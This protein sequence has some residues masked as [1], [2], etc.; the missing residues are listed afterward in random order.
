MKLNIR[1][2]LMSALAAAL[3][4]SV[5]LAGAARAD[6]PR[7]PIV[8]TGKCLMWKVSSDTATVYL[9]GS[10][11][12][13]LEKMYPLP[14]EMEEAFAKSDIVVVEINVN[15]MD[16]AKMLEMVL[17]KGMY[18]PPENLPAK[19]SK[20][21]AAA[22][23]DT[24]KKLGLPETV[25]DQM[26][27]WLAEMSLTVM[28]A[29]K[30]GFSEEKGIDKYFLGKADQAKKP[31][32][33]LED[34][35]FQI[36]LLSGDEEKKQIQSLEIALQEQKER[37]EDLRRIADA[38]V[39]G[40]SDALAELMSSGVKKHPE[41]AGVMKAL[42]DDR[43]GPMAEKAE[44]YLKG[45]KTVF[46]VVGAAHLVGEKGIVKILQDKKYKVERSPATRAKA[47]PAKKAA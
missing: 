40:D 39:A 38:W 37:L 24:C 12:L 42:L 36:N 9:V 19:L 22:L 4:A 32:E 46:I 29:M 18:A 33:E 26:K 23:H 41:M 17:K 8:D 5:A 43:N 15:K 7:K 16:Q 6:E 20:E 30:D 35:D 47:A 28:A 21:S 1:R 10:I 3:L 2:R 44:K 31:I 13:G 27:P 34:A 25:F 14:K 11:H 45:N